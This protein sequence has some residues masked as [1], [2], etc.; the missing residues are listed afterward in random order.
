MIPV[1][2]PSGSNEFLSVELTKR[3]GGEYVDLTGTT[4][5]FAFM[6]P[7][8]EPSGGDFTSTGSWLSSTPISAY[9]RTLV[10][11]AGTSLAEGTYDVW[12]RITGLPNN[13]VPTKYV[14]VL[15]IT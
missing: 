2:I 3:A 14:G 11:S 6:A 12:V 15:T 1:E 4:V 10:G 5:D 13:E 9:A 8:A 7:D